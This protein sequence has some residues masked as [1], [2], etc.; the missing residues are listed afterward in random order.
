MAYNFLI[1]LTLV[2]V[3]KFTNGI[4]PPTFCLVYPKPCS[5][6]DIFLYFFFKRKKFHTNKT[7]DKEIE[8]EDTGIR[9][10]V[11]K[12]KAGEQREGKPKREIL[13]PSYLK[14]YV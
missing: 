10:A 2:K 8:V 3:C 7:I 11:T 4:I 13:K 9:V 14:D 6:G 12:P 5:D 1:C